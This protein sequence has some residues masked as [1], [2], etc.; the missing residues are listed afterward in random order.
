MQRFEELL[1][2]CSIVMEAKP[3]P[4]TI[5]EGCLKVVIRFSAV[6]VLNKTTLPMLKGMPLQQ[7]SQYLRHAWLMTP[8]GLL[9]IN[10]G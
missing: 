1:L 7:V 4:A 10:L 9:L 2:D 5:K 8:A 6:S 3:M